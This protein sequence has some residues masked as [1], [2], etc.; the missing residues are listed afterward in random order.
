MAFMVFWT[1]Y[2]GT[3]ISMKLAESSGGTKWHTTLKTETDIS[4]LLLTSCQQTCMTYTIAVC[5]VKNSWW[6]TKELSETCKILFQ[7]KF[8]K[9]VHLVDFIVRIKNVKNNLHTLEINFITLI[10]VQ[11]FTRFPLSVSFRYFIITFPKLWFRL[12][13]TTGMR[14]PDIF[15]HRRQIC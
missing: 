1:W 7:N 10:P 14:S 13:L 9:L 11:H 2:V 6:W 5:T 8:E 15:Q 12:Q 3:N 4:F